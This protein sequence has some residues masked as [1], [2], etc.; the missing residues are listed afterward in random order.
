MYTHIRICN[1]TNKE[2][3]SLAF[4][5]QKRKR[6]RRKARWRND[7]KHIASITWKRKN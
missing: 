4:K 2:N 5:G 3:N 6:G 7:K 1:R